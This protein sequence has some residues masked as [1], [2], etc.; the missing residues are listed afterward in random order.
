MDILSLPVPRLK[1][2]DWIVRGD[3]VGPDPVCDMPVRLTTDAIAIPTIGAI[4]PNWLLVV[5]RVCTLSLADLPPDS[6]WNILN[7]GRNLAS[8]MID[9]GKPVFFEHG[10][11]TAKDIVGCGVDQAHLHVLVTEIDLLG[12]AL[13]DQTVRWTETDPIDPWDHLDNAEYYLIQNSSR[14]FVGHPRAP[15]SQYFRKLIA[16]AAGV[17]CQ[18]DYKVWPNYENVRRTYDRFVDYGVKIV[19]P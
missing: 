17:P 8:D 13:S 14:A 4:V 9:T 19:R 5:P 7:F 10:A 2:F 3:A 6:R 18:W 12:A 1:R 15:Q 16:R 11:R